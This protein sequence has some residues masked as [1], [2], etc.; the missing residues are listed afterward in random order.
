MGHYFLDTQY[1][2]TIQLLG[3]GKLKKGMKNKKANRIKDLMTEDN[4]DK[5]DDSLLKGLKKDKTGGKKGLKNKKANRIKDLMTEDKKDK[6]D[7]D[8]K[9]LKGLKNKK[10][11]KLRKKKKNNKNKKKTKVRYLHRFI[12]LDVGV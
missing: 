9:L 1:N 4:K 6:T 3:P 10:A 8:F 5:T 11:N 2:W 7:V 12:N